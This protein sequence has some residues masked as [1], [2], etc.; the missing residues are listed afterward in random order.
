MTHI[1]DGLSGVFWLFLN[2]GRFMSSPKKM[3]L[4][5]LNAFVVAVGAA[6]VGYA[7]RTLVFHFQLTLLTDGPRSLRF[8]T[9]NSRRRN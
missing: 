3:L 7:E 9:G 1:L 8:R 2:R 6:L 5:V 4:T